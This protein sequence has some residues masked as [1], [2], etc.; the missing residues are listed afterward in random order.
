MRILDTNSCLLLLKEYGILP[1]ILEHSL[2]VQSVALA[3]TDHLNGGVIINRELVSA[4]ALLHDITKSRAL[5]TGEK[6]DSS[7]KELL[8]SLGFPEIADVVGQHVYLYHD[9][10]NTPL[11][12]AHI[13][14]YADKRV[15]HDMIVTVDERIQDLLQRYGTTPERRNRI[16]KNKDTV[17]LIE[18]K[19]QLYVI[20][21]I[22]EI[23]RAV[24]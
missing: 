15:M 4:A 13:V 14:Y 18:G 7:A 3:L 23:I 22:E 6:H 20:K 9:V 21:P 12:E 1:N 11:N 10:G 2:K 17:L 19:I 16:V 24:Q 8:Q 5:K